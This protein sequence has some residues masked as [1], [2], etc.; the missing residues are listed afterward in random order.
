MQLDFSNV[1]I[2]FGIVS[3]VPIDLCLVFK[4]V[5]ITGLFW[6]L[7]RSHSF[8]GQSLLLGATVLNDYCIIVCV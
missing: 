5:I 4:A 2:D 1:W 3:I 6:M 7:F 8:P